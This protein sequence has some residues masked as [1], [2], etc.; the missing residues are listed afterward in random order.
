MTI[1]KY[2]CTYLVYSNSNFLSL[3]LLGRTNN[4][5]PKT[6]VLIIVFFKYAEFK[7]LIF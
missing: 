7:D 2:I 3:Y 5:C 1:S 4:T 6:V